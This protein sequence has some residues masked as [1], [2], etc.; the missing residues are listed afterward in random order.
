MTA[1]LGSSFRA[2]LLCVHWAVRRRRMGRR[3][4]FEGFGEDTTAPTHD[5]I[6]YMY[7]LI[8]NDLTR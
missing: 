1:F 8:N 2:L 3:W 6:D 4:D 5:L 7:C